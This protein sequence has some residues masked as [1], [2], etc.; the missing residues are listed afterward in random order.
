MSRISCSELLDRGDLAL[1]ERDSSTL[2]RITRLL[3]S[4]MGDPLADRLHHLA[5]ACDCKDLDP[6]REWLALRDAIVERMT[7]A[8]T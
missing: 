4:R 6:A 2:A 8:G 5:R 7:I 1:R 3:A